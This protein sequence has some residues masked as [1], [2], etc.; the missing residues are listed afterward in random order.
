MLRFA[1]FTAALL[2]LAPGAQAQSP[3]LTAAVMEAADQKDWIGVRNFTRGDPVIADLAIWRILSAGEGSWR[4]YSA[5]VARNPDWPNL[6]RIRAKGEQTMPS[7][8]SLGDIDGFLGPEPVQTGWG[9]LR[10]ADALRAAG[11]GDEAD[12]VLIDGWRKLSLTA[13]EFN[14]FRSFHGALIAPYHRERADEMAWRG[15]TGEAQQMKALIDRGYAA[16]IEA[17]VRLRRRANGVDAAIEA[18]PASLRSDPGLAYERFVWRMRKNRYDGA[19]EI[20]RAQSATAAQLGRPDLWGDRRRILVRRMLRQGRS[21]QAYNL[22][23]LNHMTE[24]SSYS[25]L[26]W[27][28]GWIALRQMREPDRAIAHFTRFLAAVGTP[29]SYGRGNYWM[30]R[31]HEAKGDSAAARDWY[32][33]AAEHQTSFYGQLA[34]QKIGVGPKAYLAALP[35]GNWEAAGFANRTVTRAAIAL[36]RDFDRR[37]AHWF[38]THIASTLESYEDLASIAQLATELGREDAAIRISKIAARKGHVLQGH[39]YPLNG[40]ANFNKGVEPA[41]AMAIARQESELNIEAISPAGARGLM[42]LMPATAKKVSGWLD[43]PYDRSR[44]TSDWQYNATLGQ[45]YLARRL[46]QFG[47]SVAMAAAAYNAGAGRVDQWVARYGDPRLPGVDVVDWIET[48]PFRETRNYVQ[49][50][51]EGLQVYRNRIAGGAVP[52]RVLDDAVGR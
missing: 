27:L 50:V 4:D 43:L 45:T 42:Q 22:A 12:Q 16:L 15:L 40:L 49:R 34:A 25:D 10:R 51:L 1:L 33:R 9:A 37:R 2:I 7:G 8:L 14:E 29:I 11:R 31:A 36:S 17:R 24:G 13:E 32:A 41:L 35:G 5:F 26:E 28:A 48:I 38:L 18:V 46:D 39:Y 30:G 47:G 21:I 52:F 3:G 23:N 20:I 44:L 6:K 19:E